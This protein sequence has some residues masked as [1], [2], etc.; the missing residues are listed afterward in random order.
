[1][2]E[3]YRLWKEGRLLF[4]ALDAFPVLDGA[5]LCGVKLASGETRLLDMSKLRDTPIPARLQEGM[6]DCRLKIDGDSCVIL[7]SAEK[8]QWA[9]TMVWDY[10]RDRIVHLSDTPFAVDAAV[11]EDRLVVLYLVQYWGHP[12]DLWFSAAPL[13]KVDAGFSPE[14]QPLALDLDKSV[15]APDCC[16]VS[17]QNGEVHFRAGTQEIRLSKR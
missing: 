17:V 9:F 16:Q 11:W 5:A 14:R 6:E 1:M 10:I 7:L 3:H 13:E 8:Y 15:T 4:H 12:A 2:K